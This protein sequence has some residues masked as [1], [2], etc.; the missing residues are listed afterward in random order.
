MLLL[1]VLVES[2]I[3]NGIRKFRGH[4]HSANAKVL[5]VFRDAG[6]EIVREGGP[7][8]RADMSL[9]EDPAHLPDTIVGKVL[10]TVART[11]R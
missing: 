2:A 8:L 9:P 4:V 7:L 5:G 6:A 10:R 3:R 1:G 11:A